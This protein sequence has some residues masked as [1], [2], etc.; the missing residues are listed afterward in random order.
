MNF[1]NREYETFDSL[2]SKEILMSLMVS[3]RCRILMTSLLLLL[4]FIHSQTVTYAQPTL[5]NAPTSGWVV[6]WTGI[7][8]DAD[9][10][11]LNAAMSSLSMDSGAEM[12]LF[13]TQD[14]G[15]DPS[16]Y[17]EQI[18]L[19][20]QVGLD[21]PGLLFV[22]CAN[23]ARSFIEVSD[24]LKSTITDDVKARSVADYLVPKLVV[25]DLAGGVIDMIN[26]FESLIGTIDVA[27]VT[28]PQTSLGLTT[29][30]AQA[31]QIAQEAK[32]TENL[33]ENAAPATTENSLRVPAIAG[34]KDAGWKQTLIKLIRVFLMVLVFLSIGIY[35]Y[36]RIMRN[37]TAEPQGSQEFAPD[38]ADNASFPQD[39]QLVGLS[40]V[41]LDPHAQMT[42]PMHVL[43][44]P[45]QVNLTRIIRNPPVS[46]P[47][48]Q[49]PYAPDDI[50]PAVRQPSDP[51][52]DRWPEKPDRTE[53]AP[54]SNEVVRGQL[55]VVVPQPE[56]SGSEKRKGNDPL[57]PFE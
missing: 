39:Q 46:H 31:T 3:G 24:H 10:A 34:E 7:V 19:H 51:L 27:T 20:W 41:D 56:T 55:D 35:V 50:L 33:G 36:T 9:Q 8:T 5:P 28:E 29:L 52:E 18:F 44:F 6:D 47:I 11:N 54:R 22:M 38:P 25:G 15:T 14:C 42:Q 37:R 43:D 1:D 32:A 45:A 2:T 57:D 12:Y 17:A 30:G 16:D 53:P 48:R 13:V 4:F 49:S 26:Y 40:G 23:Q 21:Q